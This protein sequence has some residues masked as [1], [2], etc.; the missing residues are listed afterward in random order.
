M[1]EFPD[2]LIVRTSWVFGPGRNFVSAIL[3]Q[4]RKRRSG[5]VSGHLAVVDDQTGSPTYAG[6]LATGL[7]SLA[8]RLANGMSPGIYQLTGA[9]ETT[10]WGFA[11]EILDRCGYTDL[12]ID[13][14]CTEE[15]SLA[16]R[17]PIYSVLDTEPAAKQGVR[18]PSWQEGLAAYLA[19]PEG[20]VLLEGA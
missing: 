3:D 12:E 17:R 5:E 10:W 15:L 20:V 1:S 14:K 19:S 6:H 2:S 18:L 11:R 7:I 16:A 9:G 4:A 13:P 8:E